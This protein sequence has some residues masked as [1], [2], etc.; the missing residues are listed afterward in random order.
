LSIPATRIL[1]L[2][3][4]RGYPQHG[5]HGFDGLS[6][7]AYSLTQLPGRWLVQVWPSGSL[8]VHWLNAM[9][10]VRLAW[11]PGRSGVA[12]HGVGNLDPAVSVLTRS[13]SSLAIACGLSPRRLSRP[14]CYA[15]LLFPP[16]ISSDPAAFNLLWNGGRSSFPE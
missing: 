4:P 8:A 1:Q 13:L 10:P 5:R 16:T 7:G 3:L 14:P 9:V 11:S 6:T 15:P 2:D 12:R